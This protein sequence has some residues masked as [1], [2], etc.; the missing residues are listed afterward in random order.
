MCDAY[1]LALEVFLKQPRLVNTQKALPVREALIVKDT[2]SAKQ[3]PC[4]CDAL[5]LNAEATN[6]D[7][8]GANRHAL[9]SRWQPYI[10]NL[11]TQAQ[12]IEG[13]LVITIHA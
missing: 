4:R 9:C 10:C 5:V 8:N 7:A 2:M 13:R 12:S 3:A 6:T 11:R 1:T